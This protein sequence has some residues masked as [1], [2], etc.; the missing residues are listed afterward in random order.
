MIN[1]LDSIAE[2]TKDF[3]GCGWVF[4]KKVEAR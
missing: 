2:R 3:T 1:Y 4:C